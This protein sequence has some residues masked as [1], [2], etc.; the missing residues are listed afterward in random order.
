MEAINISG[1]WRM[2]ENNQ[3][4]PLNYVDGEYSYVIL[5]LHETKVGHSHY[6]GRIKDSEGCFIKYYGSVSFTYHIDANTLTIR[7]NNEEDSFSY[8]YCDDK[9]TLKS[10]DP[11][12]ESYGMFTRVR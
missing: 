8:Q 11:I 4:F 5:F 10:K 1:E 9:L 7:I 6:E 3:N 12:I 2:L